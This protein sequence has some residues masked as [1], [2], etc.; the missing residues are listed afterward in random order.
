MTLQVRNICTHMY[1]PWKLLLNKGL[2][3]HRRGLLTF[4]KSL[5]EHVPGALATEVWL[6]GGVH[7]SLTTVT[8]GTELFDLAAAQVIV[9]SAQQ[10]C[11]RVVF[12]EDPL[13]FHLYRHAKV[14]T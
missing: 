6:H 5:N 1:M 11:G 9:E 2:H 4:D 12:R 8:K 3:K 14:I 10:A 13:P 7:T